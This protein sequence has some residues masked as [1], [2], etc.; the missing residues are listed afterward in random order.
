M[1]RL[2]LLF[3]VAALAACQS[4]PI[5]TM[6]YTERKTL[7]TGFIASCV[8]Q[9]ISVESRE[10]RPCVE[11]EIQREFA[12]R[13][14]NRRMGAAIGGALSDYGD[15]MQRNAN[16]RMQALQA[17]RPT[18]CDSQYLGSGTSRTVCQ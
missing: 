7:V 16:A 17:R 6:N 1:I 3:S 2:V 18:V 4:R 8:K 11:A 12:I 10:M 15:D 5:E 13:E 14:R 9:G